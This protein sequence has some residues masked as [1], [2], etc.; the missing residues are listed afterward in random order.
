MNLD[1]QEIGKDK[2]IVKELEPNC[3]LFITQRWLCYQQSSLRLTMWIRSNREFLHWLIGTCI[4]FFL[5]ATLCPCLPEL[6]EKYLIL[7]FGLWQSVVLVMS[8]LFMSIRN[9]IIGF[10]LPIWKWKLCK[11]SLIAIAN[12]IR[13]RCLSIIMMIFHSR[14]LQQP[15]MMSIKS[16]KKFITFSLCILISSPWSKMIKRKQNLSWFLRVRALQMQLIVLS[17]SSFWKF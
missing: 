4:T 14:T 2:K 1:T 3:T 17:S 7:M 11:L 13:R 6:R 8:S 10:H 16:K 15:S 5:G 9:M 12:I